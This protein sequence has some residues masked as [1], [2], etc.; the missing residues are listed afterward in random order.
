[1]GSFYLE[2]GGSL[3]DIKDLYGA[4]RVKKSDDNKESV[5]IA[6]KQ[7]E[8]PSKEALPKKEIKSG[9][10]LPIFQELYKEFQRIFPHGTEVEFM[11][12]GSVVL[13]YILGGG[14]PRGKFVEI[15]SPSGLGKS[16]I[17]LHACKSLAEQ[18]LHSL[19]LDFEHALNDSLER[20]IGVDKYRG[21]YYAPHKLTTYEDA[22]NIL[23]KY[24]KKKGIVDLVVLDSVTAMMPSKLREKAIEEIEPGLNARLMSAFLQ[25]YKDVASATNATFLFI[26]QT[27]MKIDFHSRFGAQ[28]TAAGG[29]A[30]EFYTDIRIYM[31]GAQEVKDDDNVRIGVDV[32]IEATKNRVTRPY[33]KGVMSVIFGRGIS[34][35]RS[36]I[37]YLI[38]AG[39]VV[40]SAS[41]FTFKIPGLQ[42]ETFRGRDAAA[43]FIAKNREAVHQF[44][45]TKGFFGDKG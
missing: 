7:L 24:L 21:I 4:P 3:L 45:K 8:S 15:A 25:K 39:G 34:N 12:S 17:A 38:Q 28:E 26:N 36:Y 1:M 19:Y 27:R 16:T 29:K 13:D 31:K 6:E 35:S 42:E 40:Q 9:A 44:L 41:Y 30:L 5:E 18:G 14:I 43:E 11:P 22:Q 32:G 2:I 37:L 23:D 20:G 33:V 10:D